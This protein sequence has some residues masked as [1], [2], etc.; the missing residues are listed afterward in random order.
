MRRNYTVCPRRGNKEGA[1]GEGGEE[2]SGMEE[3]RVWSDLEDVRVVG[4]G[5][6]AEGKV[7]KEKE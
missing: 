2:G 3:E 4:G 7:K 6:E 5:G 1:G